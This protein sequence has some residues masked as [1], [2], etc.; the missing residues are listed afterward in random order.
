MA[1]TPA[2]S[3]HSTTGAMYGAISAA[4]SPPRRPWRSRPSPNGGRLLNPTCSF[5]VGAFE[6]DQVRLVAGVPSRLVFYNSSPEMLS[7]QAPEFFDSSHVRSREADEVRG[8]RLVLRPG[9]SREI[10]L[11]PTRGR[12]RMRSGSLLRRALGMSAEILV[13]P[14]PQRRI[15]SGL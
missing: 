13:D 8:G 15:D 14:P 10:V 11:V 9:E 5:R 6:P 4:L 7:I 3:G 2:T 12:Y 1:S